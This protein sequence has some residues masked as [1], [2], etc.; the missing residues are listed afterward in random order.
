MSP[1]PART[2]RGLPARLLAGGLLAA[3]VPAAVGAAPAGPASLYYDRTLM[4][5]AGRRCALFVP[6]VLTSLDAGA[7]Q[8]RSAA[9]AAGVPA[10]V[11]AAT[12]G[13]AV[14]KARAVDCFDPG[15]RV[16][17]QRVRAAFM[18]WSH[19]PSLDLPDRGGGWWAERAL[20]RERAPRWAL[21]RRGVF[22]GRPVLFG[23]VRRDGAPPT[24]SAV[25]AWPQ[26]PRAYTARL[27][28]RDGARAPDPYLAAEG[29]PPPRASRA[30]LAQGRGPADPALMPGATAFSFPDAAADA[31]A[32]LDPR[33][34]ARLELVFAAPG[35]DRVVSLLLPAGDFAT[36]RAFLL[37]GR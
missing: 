13:R 5:E 6:P 24:L 11:L 21:V 2:L 35:G 3:A 8:A 28:L 32:A 10:P 18:S 14:G 20:G 9:L 26:A 19:Q 33:E 23:L 17:A 16:A 31:L 36:G 29:G 27:V 1:R 34:A 4:G 30:V 37:A 25:L 12:A 15:L 7:A 22:A